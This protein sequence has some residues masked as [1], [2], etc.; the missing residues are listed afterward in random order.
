MDN[1]D[2]V[3][4]DEGLED[5]RFVEWREE[6]AGAGEIALE[7]QAEFDGFVEVLH[8]LVEI[9]FESVTDD[10]AVHGFEVAGDFFEVSGVMGDG[11][12][13]VAIGHEGD[14][15]SVLLLVL[16]V[17]QFGGALGQALAL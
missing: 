4:L 15:V 14:L 1:L 5:A 2:F 10:K 3:F 7:G 8:G 11:L 13:Y 6:V 12:I 9:A 17:L 16:D